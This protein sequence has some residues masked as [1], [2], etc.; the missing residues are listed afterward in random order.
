M[1][2]QVNYKNNSGKRVRIFISV[3]YNGTMDNFI[4]FEKMK[5]GV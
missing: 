2:L 1:I 5:I 3:Y 4:V